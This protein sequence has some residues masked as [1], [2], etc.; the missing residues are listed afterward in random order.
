MYTDKP[1]D[2]PSCKKNMSPSGFMHRIILMPFAKKSM[3]EEE[4]ETKNEESEKSEDS[5][6]SEDS[7]ESGPSKEQIA[8]AVQSGDFKSAMDM[9]KKMT[10][11]D[12]DSDT[13]TQE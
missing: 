12:A 8:M 9:L 6:D 1:C 7:E 10:D 2:C 4:P 13:D 5:E 11:T 3:G